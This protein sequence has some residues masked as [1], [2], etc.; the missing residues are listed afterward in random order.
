V[1]TFDT[2][3]LE[4][5]NVGTGFLNLGYA[6]TGDFSGEMFGGFL[7]I[8]PPGG[9][10]P[11]LR[12]SFTPMAPGLR[13]GQL[14]I[15][16][17]AAGS[18]HVVQFS[19]N[20]IAVNAGDFTLTTAPNSSNSVTIVAGQAATYD[21]LAVSGA[22]FSDSVTL[23]CAGFPINSTC[24]VDPK[25]FLLGG[26]TFIGTSPQGVKISVNTAPHTSSSSNSPAM[27]WY[28]L[29]SFAGMLLMKHPRRR[30]SLVPLVL[31]PA[32]I[33]VAVFASCGGGQPS[34]PPSAGTPAGT[35]PIT[36]TATSGKLTHN[37]KLT[38]IVQ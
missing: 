38:L 17:N 6:F 18:P 27:P 2:A 36:L 32:L 16:D 30:I 33:F 37:I 25:T 14:V 28:G 29:I 10:A 35:Y 5:S 23:T 15:T 1:G 4:I 31:L 3:D 19:G 7:G 22:G 21:L 24:A 26:T 34:P 12:V 11:P 8:L 13:T 20:G 9:A